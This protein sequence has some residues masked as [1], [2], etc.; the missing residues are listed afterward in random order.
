[1]SN[2]R[3]VRAIGAISPVREMGASLAAR[4]TRED[5]RAVYAATVTTATQRAALGGGILRALAR[6]LFSVRRPVLRMAGGLN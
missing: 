6:S 1:M 2:C 4:E 3:S 5:P